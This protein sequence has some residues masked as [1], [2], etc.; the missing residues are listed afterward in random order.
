LQKTKALKKQLSFLFFVIFSQWV[1]AQEVS[2]GLNV[3]QPRGVLA[4]SYSQM[5]PGIDLGLLFPIRDLKNFEF[6]LSF[7]MMSMAQ[8]REE[9]EG[10][11]R[12]VVSQRYNEDWGYRLR[13]QHEASWNFL[14]FHGRQYFNSDGLMPF[15]E[16]GL[17]AS[18]NTFSS[19]ITN[20]SHLISRDDQPFSEVSFSNQNHHVSMVLAGSLG[21]GL[22]YRIPKRHWGFSISA[23]LMATTPG[24]YY[25]RS[26][27]NNID[28]FITDRVNGNTFD[29]E[30]RDL[31]RI[32]P[33]DEGRSRSNWYFVRYNFS[34]Q[35]FLRN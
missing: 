11:V 19:N 33:T 18:W 30:N 25:P 20:R 10:T 17:G 21:G 14:M 6:G 9:F 22:T 32:T 1:I 23:H 3:F 15:V 4:Q 2:V 7:S 16:A 31:F 35:Y 29:P 26:Y 28:V 24:S 34:F 5:R 12:M 8:Q 13:A 27:L